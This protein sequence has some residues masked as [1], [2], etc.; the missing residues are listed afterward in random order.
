[1]SRMVLY[2]VPQRQGCQR[3]VKAQVI[4]EQGDSLR[5]VPEGSNK[6]VLIE[7]SE[8]Q[9]AQRVFGGGRAMAAGVVVPKAY[10]DSP[11]SLMRILESRS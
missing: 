1:M 7:A 3:V 9:D 6:A 5:V 8:A 4:G 11:N 10:P 2:R